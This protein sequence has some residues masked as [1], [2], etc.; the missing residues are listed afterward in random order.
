MRTRALLILAGLAL[1]AAGPAPAQVVLRVAPR[2]AVLTPADWFYEEY[3]H[4][5]VEPLE[6]TRAA[7]LRSAVAGVAVEAALPVG[8]WVRGEV[9]RTVGGRT[10]AEHAWLR[11]VVGF[12]PPT[13][14]RT[15]YHVPTALT[16][17]TLEL[18][19]PTRL[20]LPP[21]IEP[22]VVA[23][24]GLKRYAF[25]ASELPDVPAGMILPEAGT[26]P[27]LSIGGGAVIGVGPVRLDVVVRDALSD[28]WGRQQHDVSVSLGAWLTVSRDP[29]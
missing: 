19:L 23:G 9:T 1:A 4:F 20:R 25:D 28:Y 27:M 6:W 12:E 7:I 22:Y 26:E 5:G 18:A 10:W 17:A 13:V 16:T 8:V 2:A 14:I 3:A 29:R 11:P 15:W 21:G 24:A